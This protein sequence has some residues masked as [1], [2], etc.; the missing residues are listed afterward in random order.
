MSLQTRDKILAGRAGQRVHLRLCQQL[1]DHQVALGRHFHLEQP[2]GSEVMSQ[3]ELTRVLHGTLRTVFDMCEVGGLRL[4]RGNNF[5]R[6]RTVILTTSRALHERLDSRFCRREHTHA[7]ILGQ[8]RTREGWRSV[9][10]FAERYTRGFARQVCLAWLATGR[11]PEAPLEVAELTEVV[12]DLAPEEQCLAAHAVVKRRRLTGKQPPLSESTDHHR[13]VFRELGEVLPR[14]GRYVVPA[15]G[16]LFRRL[17]RLLPHLDV[18]HIEACRGTNRKQV[19][20]AGSVDLPL[21]PCRQTVIL[22]RHDGTIQFVGGIEEWQ[23]LP[24]TRRT[25]GTPPARISFTAFGTAREVSVSQ[26]NAGPSAE[27]ASGDE[28]TG[29]PAKRS[30]YLSGKDQ[31]SPT[32]LEG[33]RLRGPSHGPGFLNLTAV[34]QQWL[35]RVHHRM[36]HP[37]PQRFARFLQDAQADDRFVAG[38]KD[39]FCDACLE[40]QKGFAATQQAAIHDRLGFNEVVGVDVAVWTSAQGERFVFLHCLDEGTLFHQARACQEDADSQLRAL[41]DMWFSWAGPPG[42]MYVDPAS[43]YCSEAWLLRMQQEDIRLRMSAT[44]SHWQL[45]RAESHGAILKSMLTRMDAEAGIRSAEDFRV[46]L[47]HAVMAKNSMSRIKGYTPEQAVLGVARKLPASVTSDASAVSHALADGNSDESLRFQQVL[48]RRL[49]AR[50]ALIEADNSSSLRRALLRRARPVRDQYEKGDW[51]LYWRRKGGNLRRDRGQWFGPARVVMVDGKRVVWLVHASRLVRASPEQLRPASLREWRQ[52]QAFEMDRDQVDRAVRACDS[53]HYLDLGDD[54]PDPPGGG[55]PPASPDEGAVSEPERELSREGTMQTPGEAGG[56]SVEYVPSEAPMASEVDG[57]DQPMEAVDVPVPDTDM[58]DADDVLFGDVLD[59]RQPD[60]GYFWELDVTPTDPDSIALRANQTDDDIVLEALD[61]RRKRVEVKLKDL[62]EEDQL[63]FAVAKDKELRAWLKHRT[64]RKASGGKIPEW[65]IM[66]C[67]WLLTWK[68]ASGT[69]PPGDANSEGLKAKARLI[70][71]GYEDPD[72]DS[73]ANDAPTL[74]KDGRLTVLQ[75]VASHKWPLISFDVSTAFLHG[76]GDGRELGLHPVSEVS[77]VL[78]LSGSDQC[79]LIGGAYGRIDAPYLWFCEFRDELVKQGCTQCPLDPCVFAYHTKNASGKTVPHGVIGI[80]V[81]DG[82][83]GGD[84]AFLDMLKRVEDRFKFGAF[85]RT[86]FVYTGIHF[87]Q[88]D[89]GSIE[90]DQIKYIE[91]ISFIA[92]EKQRRHEPDSP[93]TEKERKALRGLVGSL[94]YASVHSRPDLAVK[95]S[96][97]QSR[98]NSATVA[99]LLQGNKVLTEA[100]QHKVSLMVLPIC[101]EHVT[102]CAFSDASFSVTQGTT[103]HQGTLIFATT[104]ELLANDQ[105]VIAP[106][107]WYISRRFR[108][109]LGRH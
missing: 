44:D 65:A 10:S 79:Q 84:Q 55:D 61:E 46:A 80:H 96:Q 75:Q 5:L 1:Y 24:K 9:S 95:C 59:F 82:I 26:P 13:Q 69:E 32:D 71:I 49:Q 27:V 45:G 97:L 81:D 21:V 42:E 37:D 30:R 23:R 43:E 20:S 58:S 17:S 92:V 34:D 91:G 19:P 16:D 40:S 14:V 22:H 48:E 53:R 74:T 15:D 105:A 11:H 72:L 76:K 87:K 33:P 2:Q 104:P 94:Q 25:A 103:A 31:E 93:V 73:I 62:G 8:F 106:L 100:K 39:Y 101:P 3:P 108:G 66:R 4:P 60:S 7:P 54:C 51:V 70:V 99:D 88:W 36:G 67:R 107:A 63:R 85:D 18:R 78:S 12:C 109:S 68:P 90:Y 98:V 52:V 35:K 77:E 41:E 64:I 47:L 83:A 50:R 102:F 38:A 57:S 86:E 29:R 89:D 6:K 56:S 28:E